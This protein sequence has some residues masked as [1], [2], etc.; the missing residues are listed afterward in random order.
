MTLHQLK[1]FDCVVRLLNITKASESLHISQPSVS[2]QLKLLEAEFGR[3]FFAR[4]NYGV[5]LTRDGREFFDAIRPIL[6]QAEVVER[7]FKI[8]NGAKAPGLLKV[9][10]SHNVS[11]DVLPA[12]LMAFKQTRPLVQFILESNDSVVIEKRLL[13]SELDVGLI[14]NPSYRDELHYQP[15]DKMEVVAFCLPTNPL[16]GKTL[17]LE[18]LAESQLVMRGGGRIE[19]ALKSHRSGLNIAVRCEASAAVKAA[20]R[21]GM[22]VGILY[23]NAVASR[24]M[25]GRWKLVN[26]PELQEMGVRSFFVYDRRKPL[27][28][29]TEEFLKSVQRNNPSVARPV[30]RRHPSGVD[31]RP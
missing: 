6:E 24:L 2:Q 25:A 22:G 9:G 3:K 12:L 26:V 1:I 27:D 30:E 7:K 28:R 4:V 5:E 16:A 15:Y 29:L 19:K 10:G 14:T 8:K 31:L 23:R 21:A 17:T 18:Q 11:A 20:V 13:N